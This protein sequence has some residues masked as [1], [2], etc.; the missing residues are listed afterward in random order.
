VEYPRKIC[1]M[2][3]LMEKLTEKV[4]LRNID[5]VFPDNDAKYVI[6]QSILLQISRQVRETGVTNR[7]SYHYHLHRKSPLFRDG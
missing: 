3:A 7:M 1:K 5:L 2:K 4:S 6:T